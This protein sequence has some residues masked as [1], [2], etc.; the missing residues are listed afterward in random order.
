MPKSDTPSFDLHQTTALVTGGSRGVGR[1]IALR[2]AASGADVVITY[3]SRADAAQAVVAEIQAMDRRA[4]AVQADLTGTGDIARLSA[5]VRGALED[6]GAKGLDA[7]VHNAGV[8]SHE[9]VGSVTEAEVDRVF[10]TNYKSI[11]F[12]T[13]ALLPTLNEGGRIVAIGTGLTRFSLAGMGIYGSL[14]AALERYM[15]YLAVELGPRGI[16]ANAVAPG[17]LDTDFN[18]AAL[19]HNPG[20]RTFIEGV[21]ALGRM[22]VAEDVG[23]VVAMLCSPAGRWITGQRIEVSGGMFL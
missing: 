5:E 19:E 11:V 21:T 13:E 23:G 2:L 16:T 1:D 14:K 20:M 17:A 7:L 18:A 4:H 22:G 10:N 9:P 15:A 12:L 8:G 6:W 3:R